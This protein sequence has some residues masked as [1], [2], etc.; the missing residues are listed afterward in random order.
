MPN[1]TPF[2]RHASRDHILL[3]CYYILLIK[4]LH[5][6]KQ[7]AS[8]YCLCYERKCKKKAYFI[9]TMLFLILYIRLHRQVSIRRCIDDKAWCFIIGKPWLILWHTNMACLHF[10]RA[11]YWWKL[12][13]DS[14]KAFVLPLFTKLPALPRRRTTMI[15]CIMRGD[16]QRVL[17][18]T[19]ISGQ[20]W[21]SHFTHITRYRSR[22]HEALD[23]LPHIEYI[24]AWATRRR[25]L[26]LLNVIIDMLELPRTPPP[27][28]TAY[29]TWKSGRAIY[30]SAS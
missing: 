16:I 29:N 11:S 9:I 14:P 13:I 19:F 17:R 15:L 8:I 21:I 28:L 2:D 25:L 3:I 27:L 18:D 7:R 12:E 22:S 10:H 1:A 26:L 24:A 23:E 30:A 20:Q 5:T 6:S 4:S